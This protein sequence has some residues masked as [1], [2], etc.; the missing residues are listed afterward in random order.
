MGLFEWLKR[1]GRG[2]DGEAEPTD[3]AIGGENAPTSVVAEASAQLQAEAAE[4]REMEEG[5]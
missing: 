4:Q 1:L 2:L 3:M 5:R